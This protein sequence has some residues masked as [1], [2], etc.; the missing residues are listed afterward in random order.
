MLMTAINVF[1]GE[2]KMG[3]YFYWLNRLTHRLNMLIALFAKIRMPCLLLVLPPLIHTDGDL[4]V[5]YCR[6][7]NDW[8]KY[9]I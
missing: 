4:T 9:L 2:V 6:L 8:D 3:F 7:Y 5:F 1:R